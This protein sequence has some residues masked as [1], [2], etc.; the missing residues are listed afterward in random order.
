LAA[1]PGIQETVVEE[2]ERV[3]GDSGREPTMQDLS[4][5]HYLDRCI[6]EALRLYPNKPYTERFIHED[7]PLD[8]NK[9]LCYLL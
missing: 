6:K 3:F 9:F 4:E 7:V 8:C 1:Y 5:L 2:L